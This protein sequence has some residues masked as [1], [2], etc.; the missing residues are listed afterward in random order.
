MSLKSLFDKLILKFV[1]LLFFSAIISSN[2]IAQN[3]ITKVYDERLGLYQK[4][5][6]EI[7]K[8]K[9]GF[10]WLGTESG[11]VRFDG[12]NFNEFFPKESKYKYLGRSKIK[13]FRNYIYVNYENNGLLVFDLNTYQYKKIFDEPIVDVQPISD[14]AFVVITKSGF[15]KKIV[16]GKTVQ[17][18]KI[19]ASGGSLMALFRGALY[20]SLPEIGINTYNTSN[21]KLIKSNNR[22][23]P[24]GFN[25]SFDV[26]D[27]NLAFV[28]KSEVKIVAGDLLALANIKN[29]LIGA[30]SVDDISNYKYVT[31]NIQFYFIMNKIIFKVSPRGIS[32]LYFKD[33]VNC[34]L[35]SLLSID[36]NSFFVGTGQGLILVRKNEFS[37]AV[38]D[39]N[40][41]LVGNALR[42]RRSILEKK[43]SS[44]IL[45]GYPRNIKYSNQ[46]FDKIGDLISSTNQSILLGDDI[47][48]GND[49]AGFLKINSNTGLYQTL[50]HSADKQSYFGIYHDR[51]KHCVIAGGNGYLAIHNLQTHQTKVLTLFKER[52]S[53]RAIIYDP[54]TNK[55]WLGTAN[56]LY[57]CDQNFN[58]I[59]R[60]ATKFKNANGD[61][62]SA[63]LIPKGAKEIWAAHNEGVSIYNLQTQKLIKNL[64][65][66]LFLNR[67]TVSLIEDDFHRIWMGTYQGIIGFD[68]FINFRVGIDFEE[69]KILYLNK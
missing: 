56:G 10:L 64:P 18:I 37:N 11:L 32:N 52:I 16:I 21:L 7:L 59:T 50:A 41:P 19:A 22:I 69:M 65:N 6:S 53:I 24:N 15:L 58:I 4:Y 35:L 47:Y 68:F 46:R 45:M 66:N 43:D 5:I 51:V 27:K 54:I 25:E 14:S 30:K 67:K 60:F 40:I 62:Y 31:A 3:Y 17:Q 13:K 44:L 33:V 57:V 29:A 42:I 38:I 39:D 34:E 63:L 61:F 49:M 48:T 8:D 9:D 20:V 1:L 26:G 55:Y 23:N 12:S 36:S 28:S 2:L